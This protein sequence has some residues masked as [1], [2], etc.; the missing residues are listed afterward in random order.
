MESDFWTNVIENVI[1]YHKHLGIKVVHFNQGHAVL[2]LPYQKHFI[3]DTQRPALHGGIISTMLDAAGGAA[4]MSLMSQE[5][6]I[7]TI[8]LRVDYLLPAEVKDLL[9]EA[10][11]IR[12]GNRVIATS[13][14]AYHENSEQVVAEGR[15]VYNLRRSQ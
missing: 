9:I 10:K 7:S 15:G 12:E 13:M 5:D 2:K 4:A 11:V 8:D 6:R 1:P 3:G 14:K